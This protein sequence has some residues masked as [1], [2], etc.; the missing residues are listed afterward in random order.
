MKELKKNIYSS[1]DETQIFVTHS[2]G[3]LYIEHK[4]PIY[5]FLTEQR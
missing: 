5:V 1:W 3:A 2:F 4:F